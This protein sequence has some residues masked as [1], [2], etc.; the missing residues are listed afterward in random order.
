MGV[1]ALRAAVEADGRARVAA[2]LR[3]AEERAATL[4]AEADSMASRRRQEVLRR[5]EATLRREP[6]ARVAAAFSEAQR[7]VLEARTELVERV[8]EMAGEMAPR[9]LDSPEARETL[10]AR[11]EEALAHI[12][13]SDVAITASSG[14][15]RVLEDALAGRAGVRVECDPDLPAGF[16]AARGD[17]TLVVDATLPS[18]LGHHRATLAIELMERIEGELAR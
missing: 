2:T 15:A 5:E 11:V 12:P 13:G 16:R 4:R 18:L 7:R 17:G 9:L 3:E 14:V 10:V 6:R 1:E 8:F